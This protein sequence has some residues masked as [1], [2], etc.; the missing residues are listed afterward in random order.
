MNVELNKIAE[1]FKSSLSLNVKKSCFISFHSSK[2]QLPEL[3]AKIMIDG[4]I[5]DQV[6]YLVQNVWKGA[7]WSSGD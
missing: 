5:N 4:C 6:G 1:W 3:K 7:R 2:K